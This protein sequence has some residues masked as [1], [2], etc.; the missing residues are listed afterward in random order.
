MWKKIIY[1][2]QELN[3]EVSENGQVRNSQ[4]LEVLK[5][6]KKK[7][8]YLECCLYDQ[9]KRIYAL[10]H[11]LVAFAFLPNP[12]NYPQVNHKDGNKSNNCK[13]NLEWVTSNL[14]NQHAWDNNL[15]TP[16]VLRPVY[17][18]NLKGEF[19]KTYP[20]IAEAVRATGAKKIRDVANGV[21]KTSGGFIWQWAEDFI[22]EDRG[23]KKKVIQLTLDNKKIGVFE[24]VSEAAR[25]T[26][27]SR[28]GISA[29]CLGK[30]KTCSNYLWK[31]SDDDIV[32]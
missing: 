8:D 22:P 3:Y 29:V 4:T 14:N 25:K 24:S 13:D 32:Q 31:F 6:N 7:N 9:N 26:G 12:N 17:Q 23:R 20:S 27:A 28:K 5:L 15:N 11:R 18:Y 2:K 21:R 19:I 16:H 30:Q 1:N 10:V